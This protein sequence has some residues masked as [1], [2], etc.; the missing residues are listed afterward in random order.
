V[1]TSYLSV[2]IWSRFIPVGKFQESISSLPAGSSQKLHG[3]LNVPI[4]HH[5]TIRY[6]V[7]NGY[8]KVMSN[9][10]KMRQLP[11]PD[12]EV[13]R[14]P[15][16]ET[17]PNYCGL[18][19]PNHQLVDDLMMCF[20][21]YNPVWSQCWTTLNYRG[22][23]A[24]SELYWTIMNYIELSILIELYQLWRVHITNNHNG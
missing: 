4:E 15:K 19:N 13:W 14:I 1:S 20:S 18:R 23:Y 11:T 3:S 5:P 6:M 17:L 21:C 10:P 9:I 7:Y 2:P 22:H 16:S 24:S 12:L 8:Y